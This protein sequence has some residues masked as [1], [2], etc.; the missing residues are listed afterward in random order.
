M[1]VVEHELLL[2]AAFWFIVSAADEMAVDCCWLWLLLTRRINEGTVELEDET[3]ALQ[4]RAAVF[5]AAWQEADVIG[6]MIAHT[7]EAWPQD[8]L[9]LY[10]GCYCNDPDTIAAA[11]RGARAD[12]R[13]R[14]VVNDRKGPTT[15]ADCLNRLYQALSADEVRAGF[16]FRSVILHD[17]E[18][19]VHPAALT[20]IDRALDDAE[21]VQLPVRPEPQ[22][23]SRWVA[24]HYS[25]EFA[26]AH[27]KSM[28]VRNA[29]GAAIPA[30]GVG[31]GF[32]RDLLARLAHQRGS[33]AEQGPFA[34]DC[35]TE[36][37]ELGLL[38]SRGGGGSKFSAAAGP[39]GR[40]GGDTCLFPG[41]CRGFG[42]AEGAM[43]SWH[44]ASGLGSAWLVWWSDRYL[45]G[46]ARSARSVDGSGA[47]RRLW[48]D[49]DRSDP[50][51]CS[52]CRWQQSVGP[53]PV[54]K[55]ILAISF[56]A[57]VWRALWRFGF[58]AREYGLAEGG[59]AILRIPIANVIAIMAGRRA[60]FAYVNALLGSNVDWDKTSH[61]MYPANLRRKAA[62]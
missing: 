49:R 5:V 16:R 37:Y 4:G 40:P 23:A 55:T 43:D 47:S 60:L 31:C 26:E 22:P 19:M 9:I 54:L 11:M 42:E 24:G 13:V 34:A 3:C 15:K 17:A 46:D 21:F 53:S 45:D 36:D 38:V 56:A 30:A 50:G 41:T 58:T 28:V 2:F 29:I 18:D 32:S 35:L 14:I 33:G 7:L 52:T 51:N 62:A 44:C 6:S 39:L 61:A 59:L 20:V 57:F 12:S 48:L 8:D 25:D 1:L 10:V 27:C